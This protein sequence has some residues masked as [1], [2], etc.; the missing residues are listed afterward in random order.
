MP[1]FEYQAYGLQ[2]EFFEGRIDAAS[3]DTASEMLWSKGQTAFAM[4]VVDRSGAKWWQRELLSH[5]R[6]KP[7]DLASFTREFVTLSAAEIPLDDALR[8]L[9]DQATSPGVR[10]LVSD[11]LIPLPH[12]NDLAM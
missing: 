6:F 7:A 5:S 9:C 3:H 4:R 10:V 12:Q 11:L 2:G 1:T 8:I